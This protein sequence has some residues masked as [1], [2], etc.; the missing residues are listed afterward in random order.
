MLRQ[1]LHGRSGARS[2]TKGA[3]GLGATVGITS[4]ARGRREDRWM[5]QSFFFVSVQIFKYL[6]IFPHLRDDTV[7]L[8][9]L[10]APV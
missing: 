2:F 5:G 7:S 10:R 6:Y 8:F 1:R 4:R 3:C 9:V